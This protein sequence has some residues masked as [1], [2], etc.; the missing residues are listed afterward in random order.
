MNIPL[1]YITMNKHIMIDSKE[2][3]NQKLDEVYKILK[4]KF[5]LKCSKKELEYSLFS[6]LPSEIIVS[7]FFTY[8][9]AKDLKTLNELSPGLQDIIKH[10]PGVIKDGLK[11]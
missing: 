9:M 1:F 6:I 2:E 8:K 5:N 10:G 4:A 7:I 3:Y 11:Q